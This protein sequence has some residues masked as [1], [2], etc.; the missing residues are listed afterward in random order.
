MPGADIQ[1]LLDHLEQ[2]V[3]SGERFAAGEFMQVGWMLLRLDGGADGVLRVAEPDMKSMPI[4]YIESIDN[5][6]KTMRAQ[7][8]MLENLRPPEAPAFPSMRQSVLVDANYKSAESVVMY[9]IASE[10]TSGWFVM[11]AHGKRDGPDQLNASY[12]SLY[13]LALDRP[14]LV[15]FFALPTGLKVEVDKKFGAAPAGKGKD[16]S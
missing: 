1:W 13:Q 11:D 3:A 10:V 15:K 12:I 4:A 16:K 2:R 14:D 8:E 7:K 6:L 9:R 5:T